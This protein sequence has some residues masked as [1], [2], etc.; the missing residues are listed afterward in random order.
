MQLEKY[1]DLRP[2]MSNGI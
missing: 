2:T 1:G